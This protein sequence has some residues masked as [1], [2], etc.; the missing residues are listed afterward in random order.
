MAAAWRA[1]EPGTSRLLSPRRALISLVTGVV[2]GVLVAVLATPRLLLLVSW[3]TTVATLLTWVWR[4]SWPQDAEG[5][6]RLA[7]EE[8]TTRSTTDV[9]VLAGAVAS[10]A[11]VVA[12]LVQ[13]GD[14]QS[15][16][17]VV[18]VV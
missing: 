14:R 12:A 13:S 8:S 3:T 16:T 11:V 4:R 6:K 1:T 2:A 17:A 7:Q 5:T 9:W 15:A 18:S 10:L